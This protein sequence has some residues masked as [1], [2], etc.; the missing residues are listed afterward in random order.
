MQTNSSAYCEQYGE[1]LLIESRDLSKP[2]N[3]LENHE[4]DGTLR[5]R[6]IDWMVEVMCSYKFTNKTYFDGVNLMDRYFAAEN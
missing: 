2:T 3:C 1:E 4:I 5:A 6:M